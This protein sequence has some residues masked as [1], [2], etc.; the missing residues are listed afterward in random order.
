MSTVPY[1]E[2][3]GLKSPYRTLLILFWG[4]LMA[5]AALAGQMSGSD[6]FLPGQSSV[7]AGNRPRLEKAQTLQEKPARTMPF[8]GY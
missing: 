7:A 6:D 8:S 5:L 2:K 3:E 1:E 4:M